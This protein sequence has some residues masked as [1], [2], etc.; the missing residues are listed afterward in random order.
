MRRESG[1]RQGWFGSAPPPYRDW[2]WRSIGRPV[3]GP[4]LLVLADGRILAAGRDYRETGP[5]TA[6]DFLD[7]ASGA[8]PAGVALP[9]GGDTSYP[10]MVE[11]DGQIWMSYYATHEGKSAIYLAR[12]AVPPPGGE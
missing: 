11:H 5:V 3:G 1:D 8:W 12:L 2:T 4:E 10:G 7:P 9:S 6:V